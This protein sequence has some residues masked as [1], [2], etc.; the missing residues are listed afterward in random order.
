MDQP[1]QAFR[2]SPLQRHLWLL[3][4][5]RRVLHCQ[6]RLC[7]EGPIE[8]ARLRGALAAA[9]LRHEALRTTFD[10]PS[11]FRLP[12]QTVAAESLPAWREEDLSGLDP[13][14]RSRCARRLA[15]EETFAAE[16]L[17]RGPAFR[18]L[19]VRL[20]ADR[21]HLVLTLPSLCAD[22]GTL[23]NLASEIAL[24]LAGGDGRGESP[25]QYAQFA[26]WQ[27]QLA[28]EPDAQAGLRFWLE[29]LARCSPI[30]FPWA[31]P[32]REPG[33]VHPVELALDKGILERLAAVADDASVELADVVLVAW[34]T[35]LWRLCG[36]RVTVGVICDG[37]A[38]EELRGMLGP[39]ARPLPVSVDLY[40]DLRF[41]EALA[42]IGRSL[43]EARSQQ[44]TFAL[45]LAPSESGPN[46][47]D[48]EIAFE[49]SEEWE[50]PNAGPV[51]FTV[52]GWTAQSA[53]PALKLSCRR[54]AGSLRL[55]LEHDPERLDA[56]EVPPLA[57]RL[58]A[59]LASV[60]GGADLTL[61]ELDLLGP[62]ERHRTLVEFNDT[63]SGAGH[64]TLAQRLFE[65][66]V[67]ADPGRSAVECGGELLSYGELNA[68][69]NRLARF[70]QRRGIEPDAVVAVLLGRSPDLLPS[71]L[72]ILKAGGAYLPVDTSLPSIR[73]SYLLADSGARLALVAGGV[74]P[75]VPDSV[76]VVDLTARRAEIDAE[77]A[78]D[79]ATAIDDQSLAYVIYTSGSTGAPKGAM[80]SH[81]GLTNYLTWCVARYAPP[82]DGWTPIHSP[83]GF[84]LT[85][86]ALFAPLLAGATVSLLP[87]D[88]GLEALCSEL[89][90]PRPLSLLK[91]TPAHLSALNQLLP[92]GEVSSR[93]ATLV[94]GGEALHAE[95]IQP[96]LV[97][98]GARVVNEYGPTET[99]VGC[100]V[101]ELPRQGALAGAVPIGRPIAETRLYVLDERLEPVPTSVS[102]ELF[103]AGDGLARGYLARPRLTAERFL[104]D[105][106]AERAGERMYRTGD[107]VRHRPEG[108]L[109][110]LG[111]TDRQVKI[112]GYRIEPGEVEAVLAAHPAVREAAVVV[113]GEHAESRLAA[114]WTA[115]DGAAP[116]DGELRAWLAERLPEPLLPVALVRL[117]ELPLTAN[118]KVDRGQLAALAVDGLVRSRVFVA[119]RT[120]AEEELAA[121]WARVLGRDPVGV[122]DNFFEL[123]GHS[124]L[125]TRLM[126][127][128]SK[129]FSVTLPLQALFRGPTVEQL[130]AE[131][132]R[133][134]AADVAGQAPAGPLPAV[135]PDPAG[136]F[137]AFA[138]TDVQYAYWIGRSGALE[139]GG[140]AS[141]GS[142]EIEAEG[143]DLERLTGVLRRLIERHDMLRMIVRPDGL[144]QVLERVPPFAIETLDLRG[145]PVQQVEARLA[146]LWETK[147]HQV[148]PADRWPLFDISAA[149]LDG[150]RTRL[151][152]SRDALLFDAWSSLVLSTE[153]LQLYREPEA[154]LEPLE[155]T[156]RDYV[157]AEERVRETDLY[158]RDGQYWLE[159]LN[160]LPPA[161]ELPLA[162]DPAVIAVPRFAR[163]SSRLDGA[164]WS[165]LRGLAASAGLTPSGI[166]L[167]AFADI[168]AQWSKT[169]HF[170]INLT[171][172]NRLPLHPQVDALVGDF[173]SLVLLEVDCRP[174]D[175]FALRARRLQE[176]LWADLEHRTVTGIRV[177]R[178]LARRHAMG[179]GARMPVVLTS[180]LA[181]PGEGPRE[182]VVPAVAEGPVGRVLRA[183]T[184][185]PQVWL[186]HQVYNDGDGVG[187]NWDFVERLFPEGLVDD[188]FAGYLQLLE[189]LAGGEEAWTGPARCWVP[190]EQLARRAEVNATAAAL[191]EMVLHELFL[192]QVRRGEDK[193]AV[194]A[195]A[196]TLT[197]GEL[198][199]RSAALAQRIRAAGAAGPL[200]AVVMEKGWE[201]VVAVLGIV[202]S[203]AAYLPVDPALPRNRLWHLLEAGGVTMA[204]TQPWLDEGL[205]WPPQ[206]RRLVVSSQEDE[207]E[208]SAPEDA[209]AVRP[210]DLAYVIY[211]SG[212]TGLPKGVMIDHRGAVNT[213][214][215]V[216]E[217]FGIGEA[218]RIL[219]LSSLSF[220]LSVYDV[221][222][223]LAA[224]GAIVLPRAQE[225][226]DPAH[227]AEM[228]SR[229]GATVWNSVPAL[230]ELLVEHLEE[231][232]QSAPESLRLALLSGDWIPVRLPDRI[233]SQ[234]RGIQVIGLGGATEASI[235]SILYPI[236]EVGVD[237]ASIPY[238]R[239]MRNQRFHVL[240]D[241]LEPR[242]VWVPGELY[243]GGLGLARGYWR[244]GE[245]TQQRFVIHPRTGER[246]YRTGDL[247]RYLPSGD[248]EFLGREDFQVK[249]QG[250][251]IELGEIEAVLGQHPA[252][253]SSVV[254]AL[255]EGTQ[256]R[257]VAYVVPR[258]G[259]AV[260]A[261]EIRGFVRERLPEH[262][263]PPSFVALEAL[264]LTA[265]G[266][267]DRS[268]LP[269]LAS[270]L[271]RAA[272][273]E[274]RNELERA[275]TRLWQELLGV[276]RVGID[277]NFFDLGGNSVLLVRLFRGLRRL[278]GDELALGDVIRHPTIASLS[279][280]LESGSATAEPAEAQGPS[281]QLEARR[282]GRSR[283]QERLERGRR[284]Q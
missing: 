231:S 139:L 215:D 132:A 153:L 66:R 134:R 88:G 190:E 30:S 265:N 142:M 21:H 218:D 97:A 106:W 85:V 167:A 14:S 72:G 214:L 157:L 79:L 25:V 10:R 2:L 232:P 89:A 47:L 210:E 149:L 116:P 41:R 3:Q 174:D 64:G 197:Y 101:Y 246:L 73:R 81:R 39:C 192:E 202:R 199:R 254:A 119:P 93:L 49:W 193:I 45:H 60:T 175:T 200:V 53:R 96:W 252:V 267:V 229:G 245:K 29:A 176:Q 68:R 114:F 169:R 12:V 70:L 51:R 87:E 236:G 172:F 42:E 257:L 77:S 247:G 143:L 28:D 55:L 170:T 27:N 124:L 83:I 100:C 38:Y 249:V 168:L 33:P 277:E 151:V 237:W 273:R 224:G 34:Y 278:V 180:T 125:A 220:D 260:D 75:E 155:I 121:I 54:G 130:A 227:W 32:P 251:R 98:G 62:E 185:T 181:R 129:A 261:E 16:D 269:Q 103:I 284:A 239:P 150:G 230:M 127:Q 13:R 109:E 90:R 238:G 69:A 126:A 58:R 219:A 67:A 186:D 122:H 209:P 86:T 217:R 279:A 283:M 56:R 11:G 248:I 262:M 271:A 36:G 225:V 74:P 191:P 264:P 240:D 194:M 159:R 46:P 59:L 113:K 205:E 82:R 162:R 281:P 156:F 18:A 178:E 1:Q 94:V 234:W 276:E 226:P 268:A 131:V 35:L 272:F 140:V 152:V 26:E 111:R 223:A 270:A 95:T 44:D 20:E 266:K 102:G 147:S 105:P 212:S 63:R 207:D 6:A 204:A 208:V 184:Q 145:V 188:M 189:H 253:R 154:E 165:R 196:Q 19:L 166:F 228:A 107:L 91:V 244:D 40:P 255:G 17:Q 92:V 216:N 138:L 221:F 137:E 84:D 15:E 31:G 173:T 22:A 104:P 23:A 99:V 171:L 61:G 256:R 110:F 80:I 201:Q 76:E 133:S 206:V 263:V 146:E 282:E 78:S 120:P 164:A 258:P 179:P 222:G 275:M 195:P 65:Q 280:N 183:I 135:R 108:G 141:H 8:P 117:V 9:S 148:L 163:R 43:A 24:D 71:L 7:L 37:R 187:F 4:E 242:P 241:A 177:L 52:E 235:W 50:L 274:P 158:R 48:R 182:P 128:V 123:G 211:T 250:H 118:G 243:I 198:A 233:R 112:R 213:I 144:Q 161:P 160:T 115:R 57:A 203:G 259:Q 136:R 5:D